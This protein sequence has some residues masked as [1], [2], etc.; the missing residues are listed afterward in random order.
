MMDFL[1]FSPVAIEAYRRGELLE[2]G[3]KTVAYLDRL[4]IE[5]QKEKK[6][7]LAQAGYLHHRLWPF[8]CQRFGA[9]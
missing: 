5:S 8:Y 1:F 7:S 6:D 4:P 9:F 3:N 2:I